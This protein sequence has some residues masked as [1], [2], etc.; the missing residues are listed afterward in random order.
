MIRKFQAV[1]LNLLQPVYFLNSTTGSFVTNCR[2][3]L[4][5]HSSVAEFFLI[6]AATNFFDS[7]AYFFGA[8]ANF[9]EVFGHHNW[10]LQLQLV[11]FWHPPLFLYWFVVYSIDSSRMIRVPN[12]QSAYIIDKLIHIYFVF[13]PISAI[14][15]CNSLSLSFL[16]GICGLC[17]LMIDWGCRS[18]AVVFEFA[19][20]LPH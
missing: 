18:S 5:D 7:A 8:A 16:A 14:C 13:I 6:G 11:R 3:V 19:L 2:F 9:G 15:L 17:E 1:V 12:F 20:Y 4:P 10:C